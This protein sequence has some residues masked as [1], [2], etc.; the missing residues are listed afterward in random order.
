MDS[1]PNQASIDD[2]EHFSHVFSK[3]IENKK[4]SQPTKASTSIDD[5][6]LKKQIDAL[7]IQYK[8]FDKAQQAH[9]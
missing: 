3:L 4:D 1:H 7:P 6:E 9:A 8:E 2:A 5:A